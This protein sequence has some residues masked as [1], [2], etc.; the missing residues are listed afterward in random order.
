MA[1]LT[2]ENIELREDLKQLQNTKS[3]TQYLLTELEES[4]Q[5]EKSASEAY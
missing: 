1:A 4:Q 5:R 3:D 2:K